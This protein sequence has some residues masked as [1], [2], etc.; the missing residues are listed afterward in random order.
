MNKNELEDLCEKIAKNL[1]VYEFLDILG[2][3]MHDLVHHLKDEINIH[4]EELN[5]ALN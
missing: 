3:T 5:A 2:W 4:N 1:D